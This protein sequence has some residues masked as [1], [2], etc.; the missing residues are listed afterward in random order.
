MKKKLTAAVNKFLRRKLR[1]P[2]DE[3]SSFTGGTHKR[4]VV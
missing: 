3:T 4:I 2:L 1:V